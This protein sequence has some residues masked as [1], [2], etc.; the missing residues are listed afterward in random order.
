MYTDPIQREQ[1]MKNMSKTFTFLEK[2]ILP[3]L[4]RSEIGVVYDLTGYSDEEL[5][6]LSK[7]T[8]DSLDLEELLFTATLVN[9][10][11]DKLAI[12]S[13]AISKYPEDHRAINNAGVVL[14]MQNKLADAKDKF[15][16]ANGIK[17]NSIAINNLAAIAGVQGDRKK[18]A[19][20]LKQASGA[21]S[22]VNYNLGILNIMDGKYGDAVNNLGENNFNKALAQFL[23]GAIDQAIKTIDASKDKESAQGYY[24]KAI[25]A[26]KSGKI[27]G[28]VSNLKSSIALDSKFKEKAAKDREFLVFFENA[29]FTSI[30]K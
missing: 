8:I 3:K 25:A 28:V 19:E 29:S 26:A 27:E 9:D 12:Y 17:N 23:N 14:Y 5:V 11:N 10:L 24:L 21:G 7:S 22:E 15:E 20:L 13:H 4:R 16:Q 6:A 18:A 2:N 30:V 1:E